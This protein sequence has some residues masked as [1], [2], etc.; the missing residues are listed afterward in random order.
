MEIIYD[1]HEEDYKKYLRDE[2]KIKIANSWLEN[3]TLD[4]WRHNRMLAP[5]EVFIKKGDKWLTIGDGRYGSEA[6]WL[7][8]KGIY[9]HASDMCINLLKE[10]HS[11]GII[12]SYSKEN[13]EESSFDSAS[14]DYVL[15]KETLHHLPRPWLALYEAFRVCRKGVIIIEPNDSFSNKNLFSGLILALKN[16]LKRK[17]KKDVFKDDYN[18]EEVGNFI[19][20]FNLRELE[21]FLLGKHKTSIAS[22]KLNDHYFKGV[23]MIANKKGTLFE[24][25]MRLKLKS[26]IRFKNLL[27]NFGL[28]HHS[29]LEVVLFKEKP[30]STLKKSMNKYLWEYKDLPHNPYLN[31][32]EE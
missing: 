19:Y 30:K 28:L 12:D 20:T 29:I 17:Q 15:I 4:Y 14:F 25:L 31:K 32:N 26:Y 24:K 8:K 21:K 13:A 22:K 5:L 23:E 2:K 27:C 16:L 10:S 3:N 7:K 9:C 6:A 18:F 1:N 11:M